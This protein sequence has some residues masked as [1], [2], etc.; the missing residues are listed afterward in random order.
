MDADQALEVLAGHNPRLAE[1]LGTELSVLEMVV[2]DRE[3]DAYNVQNE[4]E[5]MTDRMV[6]LRTA[7]EDYERGILDFNELL[8]IAREEHR[9]Y[10]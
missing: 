9:A 10:A 7:I 5:R 3:A 4:L 2:E 1:V 6:R 8:T